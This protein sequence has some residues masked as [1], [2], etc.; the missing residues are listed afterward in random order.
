MKRRIF[1]TGKFS[2]L[3]EKNDWLSYLPLRLLEFPGCSNPL[4]HFS[5]RV[6][7]SVASY[8]SSP[9]SLCSIVTAYL[10]SI[11]SVRQYA[12][13]NHRLPHSLGV[14]R[15]VHT[16]LSNCLATNT[17]FILT[18]L[19][20]LKIFIFFL[21]LPKALYDGNYFSPD[22]VEMAALLACNASAKLPILNKCACAHIFITL[23]GVI[24]LITLCKSYY[25][26]L[27]F[28][29]LLSRDASKPKIVE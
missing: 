8:S 13:R 10:C 24:A 18:N 4:A 23:S 25:Y 11:S 15:F 2:W 28:S 22:F 16:K 21:S 3:C 19:C 5:L 6:P 20:R 26:S 14:S 9:F 7:Y 12:R 1:E 29:L 27:C 17:I